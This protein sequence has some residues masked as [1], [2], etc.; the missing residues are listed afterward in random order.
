MD[1]IELKR[2]TKQFALRVVNVADET[3]Y[4]IELLVES[5]MITPRKLQPLLR[6]AN[7]LTAI[8]VASRISAGRSMQSQIKNQK[9]KIR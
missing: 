2:R 4:W 8:M 6:E 5:G 9:P 1:E 3:A 7:E